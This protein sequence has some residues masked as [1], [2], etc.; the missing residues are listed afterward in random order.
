MAENYLTVLA[1]E[2]SEGEGS[3]SSQLRLMLHWDRIAFT[4]LTEAM[5]ACC[6]AYDDQGK[7]AGHSNV[8]DDDTLVP[9]W[10][11]EGFWY[12]SSFVRD[13]TTHPAWAEKTRADQDY[14]DRAYERLDMLAY[15]FFTGASPSSD[16]AKTFAPM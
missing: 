13:W 8:A 1:Y 7:L 9:R 3:F 11:A 15:W 5:L 4:R 14:Y 10:L 2:F 16:T 6:Q 12:T